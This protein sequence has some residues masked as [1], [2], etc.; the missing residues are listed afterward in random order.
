MKK[1]KEL[2]LSVMIEDNPENI[3]HFFDS[4]IKMIYLRDKNM[5]KLNHQNVIEVNNWVDIYKTISKL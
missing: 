5:R 1:C 4:N 3:E 2:E